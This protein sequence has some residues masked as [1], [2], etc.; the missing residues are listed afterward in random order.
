ML[1]DVTGARDVYGLTFVRMELH[2]PVSGPLLKL[3]QVFLESKLVSSRSDS[4]VD[5]RVISEESDL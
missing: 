1:L 5:N 3:I 4:T 2:L